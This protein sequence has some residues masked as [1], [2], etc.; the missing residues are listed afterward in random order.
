[1]DEYKMNFADYIAWDI[2]ENLFLDKDVGPL[3]QLIIAAAQ[4]HIC[5]PE[6]T[7]HYFTESLVI[8]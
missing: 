5:K 1:M 4:W 2:L 6:E 7:T 8:V 3:G